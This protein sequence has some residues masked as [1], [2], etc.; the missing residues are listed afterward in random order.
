MKPRRI[1]AL[2]CLIL[3]LVLSLALVSCGG[4]NDDLVPPPD[5][6]EGDGSNTGNNNGGN[7]DT[8]NNNG[9]NTEPTQVTV[10]FMSGTTVYETVTV[11]KG[12]TVTPPAE[13]PSE[14]Y[15]RFLEWQKDGATYDFTTPVNENITLDALY[16]PA[17]FTVRFLDGETVLDT[18]EIEYGQTINPDDIPTAPVKPGK[19][20]SCYKSGD[21]VLNTSGLV[22][23]NIDYTATYT[24]IEYTVRL[25]N[26]ADESVIRTDTLLWGDKVPAYTAPV[27]YRIVSVTKDGVAYDFETEIEGSFDLVVTLE[28]ITHTVTYVCGDETIGTV[29]APHGG[30]AA[31]PTPPDGYFWALANVGD[32]CNITD[33][34]TVTLTKVESSLYE[35]VDTSKITLT[36]GALTDE[37][38]EK[39]SIVFSH[40]ENG[41]ADPAM[42]AWALVLYQAG[43]T[44]E[45]KANAAGKIAFSGNLDKTGQHLTLGFYIDGNLWETFEVSKGSG[46]PHT[47]Q[48]IPA[49][50]HTFRIVVLAATVD[51]GGEAFTKWAGLAFSQVIYQELKPTT[52]TVTFKNGSEVVDTVTVNLGET[53]SALATNPTKQYYLFKEWQKDGVAYDFTAAVNENIVLTAVFERDPAYVTVTFNNEGVTET[54]FIEKNTKA[55]APT[56]PTKDGYTFGGWLLNGEVFNFETAVAEDITLTAKWT[57]DSA[58]YTITFVDTEG[59]TIKTVK[60]LEGKDIDIAELPKAGAK[61]YYAASTEDWKKCFGVTQNQTITLTLCTAADDYSNWKET[62]ITSADG[63]TQCQTAFNLQFSEDWW[64]NK[65]NA[66]QAQAAGRYLTISGDISELRFGYYLSAVKGDTPGQSAVVK[67]YVDDC[68]VDT[69]TFDN[70]AGTA[71]MSGKQVVTPFLAGQHTI[72]IEIAEGS[73]AITCLGVRQRPA[74]ATTSAAQV[75]AILVDTKENGI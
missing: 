24:D 73:C 61:Q 53:V 41:T 21:T 64:I 18:L 48:N 47:V 42:Q 7:T 19:E 30:R 43:Q 25:I 72:K 63:V 14:V 13:N 68:L 46:M 49:G 57:A 35:A 33:D 5:D 34:K 75:Q 22:H 9:G 62:W 12:E 38:K 6:D 59:T 26:A 23:R 40:N 1:L 51:E 32:V 52:A 27:G 70:S 54:V 37:V 8:G 17:I 11:N 55:T 15:K 31:L 16:G 74:A 2:I 58:E 67:V 3:A 36:S 56:A 4:G 10:T 66:G 60:V 28:E 65:G 50:M 71:A 45:W 29:T 39:Y 20:F 69:I 44:V